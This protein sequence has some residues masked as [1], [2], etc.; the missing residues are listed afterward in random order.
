MGRDLGA[1]LGVLTLPCAHSD[2]SASAPGLAWKASGW[3]PRKTGSGGGEGLSAMLQR[4]H[5]P[6]GPQTGEA[7]SSIADCRERSSG[8]RVWRYRFL[9]CCVTLDR[10]LCQSG[11]QF[12]YLFHKVQLRGHD[13]LLNETHCHSLLPCQAPFLRGRSPQRHCHL[14]PVSTSTGPPQSSVAL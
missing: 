11:P 14:S 7:A 5:Y 2:V 8:P 6:E 1:G 10:E 13:N 9:I 3:I 12:I 4:D